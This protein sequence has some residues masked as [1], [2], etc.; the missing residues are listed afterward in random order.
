MAFGMTEPRHFPPPWHVV[1]HAD[2]FCV[3]DANGFAIVHIRFTE[4]PE[5][6]NFSGRLSKE[7]ARY[8]AI[9]V[10]AVPRIEAAMMEVEEECDEARAAAPRKQA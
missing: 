10:A 8:V 5:L 4:D 6:L 2:T 9:R 7:E 1:E 3:E